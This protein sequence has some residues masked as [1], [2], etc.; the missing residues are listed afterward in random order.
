MCRI[1]RI[2]T[3]A[4]LAV[5]GV[6]PFPADGSKDKRFQSA[7]SF[8]K[9]VVALPEDLSGIAVSS[10]VLYGRHEGWDS[11]FR[12]NKDGELF[13]T[14]KDLPRNFTL[15]RFPR[16][17]G[18]ASKLFERGVTDALPYWQRRAMVATFHHKHRGLLPF[19]RGMPQGLKVVSAGRSRYTGVIVSL[20]PPAVAKLS[21]MEQNRNI[22]LALLRA[23]SPELLRSLL[24]EPFKQHLL[25]PPQGSSGDSDL[26]SAAAFLVGGLAAIFTAK[27]VGEVMTGNS[28]SALGTLVLRTGS[29]CGS[30]ALTVQDRSKGTTRSLECCGWGNLGQKTYSFSPGNYELSYVIKRCGGRAYSGSGVTFAVRG[31]ATTYLS[32]DLES[33][34]FRV[35]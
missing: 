6:C 35:E 29:L 21:L 7:R 16:R 10:G 19:S 25:E 32:L 2:A 20:D 9:G 26:E 1:N 8:L 13:L 33:E 5:L 24:D 31:N 27:K 12:L 4:V 3:L 17:F 30:G 14:I 11:F 34:S 18:E 15:C 23:E 28:L 22:R